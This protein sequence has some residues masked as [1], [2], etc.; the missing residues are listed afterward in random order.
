MGAAMG[1]RIRA[2]VPLPSSVSISIDPPCR[3]ATP[4]AAVRPMP[5]WPCPR[6]EKNGSVQRS[7]ILAGMPSPV[8]ERSRELLRE[9]EKRP[10][11]GPPTH[12]LSLFAPAAPADAEPDPV[13]EL[14]RDIDPDAMTPREALDALYRLKALSVEAG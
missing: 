2:V 1:I 9:L 8:I 11:Y 10:R 6:V 7:L 4:R 3:C 12:Q 14:L 5:E 13:L